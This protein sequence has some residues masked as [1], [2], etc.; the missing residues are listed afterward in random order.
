MQ[1][2]EIEKHGI[3]CGKVERGIYD[4]GTDRSIK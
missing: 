3:N 1:L 2:T 4:K